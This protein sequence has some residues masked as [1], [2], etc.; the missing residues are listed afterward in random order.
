MYTNL[1]THIEKILVQSSYVFLGVRPGLPIVLRYYLSYLS[2]L[3]DLSQSI[4]EYFKAG[5]IRETSQNKI[6]RQLQMLATLE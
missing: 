4:S 1:D 2:V 3:N 6:I 5:E